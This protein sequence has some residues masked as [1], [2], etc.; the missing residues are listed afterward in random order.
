MF[1]IKK[2]FYVIIF[3]FIFNPISKSQSIWFTHP[4]EG[5]TVS[6][7]KSSDKI[8]V[9]VNFN[10]IATESR[11]HKAWLIKLYTDVGSFQTRNNYPFQPIETTAG[12][13]SWRIELWEEFVDGSSKYLANQTVNFYV[14]YKLFVANIFGGGIINV[15]GSTV[16]SG[17]NTIK[18]I[19][20]NISVGAI[21]QNDGAGYDRIWNS[22]GI[23]DSYWLRGNVPLSLSRNYIYTVQSGDNGATLVADLKKICYPTFQNSFTNVGNG[24]VINVNGNSLISPTNSTPVVEANPISVSAQSHTFNGIDYSFSNWNDGSTNPN[25]TFYPSSNYTYTAYFIGKPSN[26]GKDVQIS[27]VVN[28]PI[29][30]YWTDNVNPNV[31]YKIYRKVFKNGIWSNETLIGEVG[32]GVQQFEDPDY[33]LANFKQYDLLNYDVRQFYTIE[34]TYSD[35]QWVSVY[36]QL[37]KNEDN[38][39]FV[40]LDKELPDKFSISNYPNPFN[41]TT[42]IKYEL[43]KDGFISIKIYDALG[44]EITTLVND[45]KKAGIYTTEFRAQS[46][47]LSSG[48]YFCR[49]VGDNVNITSKLILA[50]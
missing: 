46:S 39:N 48:I 12:I 33:L 20:E 23:N 18:L 5:I 37:Y 44:K 30:I 13:K 47:E 45:Y 24:G 10:A 50:K 29:V 31:V 35:P 8:A 49:L 34:N 40:S 7:V 43:P 15:D 38:K 41:P 14:K 22:S 1:I 32:R 28:S 11:Y 6:N 25:T 3:L 26:V 19:G 17:S 16:P 9:S 2:L 21:D 4:T 42:K 27:T 36:G